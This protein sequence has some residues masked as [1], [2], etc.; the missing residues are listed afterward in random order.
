MTMFFH[1]IARRGALAG[2]LFFLGTAPALSALTDGLIGHWAFDE[3]TSTSAF[4][5]SGNFSTGTLTGVGRTA[6]GRIGGALDFDGVGDDKVVIPHKALFNT[7]SAMSLSIWVYNRA[8]GCNCNISTPHNIVSKKGSTYNTSNSWT[9]YWDG[10]NQQNTPYYMFRA[11]RNTDTGDSYV[12]R[13]NT[14]KNVWIHLVAVFDAGFL[15]IY[16][17]GVLVGGPNYIGATSMLLTSQPIHL[18]GAI[19]YPQPPWNGLLDDFRLYNRAVTAAEAQQ[20]Y[21]LGNAA[22]TPGSSLSASIGSLD[23][24][25]VAVSWSTVSAFGYMLEASTDS[26]FRGTGFSSVTASA[27]AAGLTVGNLSPNTTYFLRVAVA[28]DSFSAAALAA[29]W[30]T[31]DTANN[32]TISLANNPGHLQFARPGASA[33]TVRVLRDIPN[34][35]GVFETK[36]DGTNLGGAGTQGYG[37]ILLQADGN[38]MT[39]QYWQTGAGHTA[40]G[41][42]TSGG[43][44]TEP[45]PRAAVT[46]GAANYLR[47]TR[48]SATYTL[49]HRQDLGAWTTVG[50]FSDS[51]FTPMKAGLWLESNAAA[52]ATTANFDYYVGPYVLTNPTATVTLAATPG[53][54]NF[55]NITTSQF[56]ARWGVNGNPAGTSYE[57]RIATSIDFTTVLDSA[58]TVSSHTVFAALAANTTFFARVRAVNFGGVQTAD[59]L[60]AVVTAAGLLTLSAD[61]V[62]NVWSNALTT[63]F[64]AQG[65]G[66][67]RYFYRV[68]A[69]AGDAAQ[70]TDTEFDGS[71]TAAA[72]AEGVN[73][74][75]VLGTDGALTVIGRARFGPITIDRSSPTV[76]AVSAQRSATNTTPIVDGG[77]TFI[78]TP[79]M[80]WTAASISPIV[81]YSYSISQSPLTTPGETINT[82]LNYTDIILGLPAVYYVKVRAL[83]MAGTFGDP[84]GMSFTYGAIPDESRVTIRNNYFNPLRGEC[85]SLDIQVAAAGKIKAVVYTLLGQKVAALVD[86]D[87]APGTY[88]YPWCGRNDAGQVVA[89]GGYVLR[90]ETPGEKKTLKLAVGK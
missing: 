4:D 53:A 15:R 32:A 86:D 8:P 38:F 12:F 28:S 17:N 23:V 41:F 10:K 22:I 64:F 3:A 58:T 89:V 43:S 73:Y 79:R 56:Q 74:I 84:V 7:S 18:G 81:G 36:I 67:T 6:A 26:S 27:G 87:A 88:S 65:A 85:A 39:F 2:A 57:V 35:N 16:E 11:R 34:I 29:A 30:V 51:G 40:V 83:N 24:S 76:F 48:S 31:S 69:N 13:Q 70:V 5:S 33:G 1:G 9:L 63:V 61:K 59:V 90:V 71:A 25:S 78:D 45:I 19:N 20:L 50:S 80:F 55:G 37:L 66:A 62:P 54:M 14:N 21:E 75:H 52:P 68:N 42:R 46:L 72:V 49:E 77:S 47:V 60:G 82:T 44:T